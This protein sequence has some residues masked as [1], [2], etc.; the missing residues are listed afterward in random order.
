MI[1]KYAFLATWVVVIILLFLLLRLKSNFFQFAKEIWLGKDLHT[2]IDK[3][4]EEIPKRQVSNETLSNVVKHVLWRF[5]RIGIF[6][7][8]FSILPSIFIA[9]QVLL[10]SN[11]NE[12]LSNQ[13]KLVSLQNEKIDNQNLLVELDRKK[14]QITLMNNILDKVDEELKSQECQNNDSTFSTKFKCKLSE[15]LINRITALSKAFEEYQF[16]KDLLET[17]PKFVKEFGRNLSQERGH[18]F[19]A[20][21][22]EYLDN[23]TQQKIC[24]NGDFTFTAIQNFTL[25]NANLSHGNFAGTDFY[26]SVFTGTNFYE[27]EF[28]HTNFLAARMDSTI[29]S[30]ANFW[31][32]DLGS[33]NFSYC[34]AVDANF[35]RARIIGTNFINANLS[36]SSF[37]E[38]NLTNSNLLGSNVLGCDF[39]NADLTY[40]DFTGV[41]NLSIVQLESCLSLFETKG[42]PDDIIEE[43][44]KRK[45]CLFERYGCK[46]KRRQQPT[47][48]G[49][50]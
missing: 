40:A 46:E 2:S 11:Q 12:L 27:T 15:Q 50:Q 3:L 13:N 38:A 37:K 35:Y 24:S 17:E 39:E 5:T 26:L 43:L 36:E 47:K 23:E 6:L 25:R 8:I 32:S 49:G 7:L 10:L 31:N 1:W 41:S 45:P 20:V 22:G 14:S 48:R 18:L 42:I 30:K 19:L 44:K 29:I 16:K 28:E 34:E 9:I 33:T 21:M 4:I